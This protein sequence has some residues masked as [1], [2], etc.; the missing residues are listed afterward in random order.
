MMT[1]KELNDIAKRAGVSN[2]ELDKYL[3]ITKNLTFDSLS[4]EEEDILFRVG[5]SIRKQKAKE[6]YSK[7]PRQHRLDDHRKIWQMAGA[8]T[9]FIA[10]ALLAVISSGRDGTA[11]SWAFAYWAISLPFLCGFMIIDEIIRVRQRRLNSK[12]RGLLAMGGFG[13]SHLGTTASV[14]SF[15]WLGAIVYF[16]SPFLVLFYVH[17][18]AALGGSEN[19]EDM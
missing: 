16:L 4:P 15:S 1:D 13:L 6:D 10:G 12:V 3:E 11:I 8:Y 18:T 14:S 2:E 7:R 5:G 17:E 19:F 9:A